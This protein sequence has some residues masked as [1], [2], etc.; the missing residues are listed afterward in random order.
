MTQ[1]LRPARSMLQRSTSGV[2]VTA[3]IKHT[4]ATQEIDNM[5][6]GISVLQNDLRGDLLVQALARMREKL[7]SKFAVMAA[8]HQM[9]VDCS[10]YLDAAELAT[11]LNQLG[12]KLGKA[13][14]TL[15]FCSID[16]DGSGEIDC[17]EFL[18]M[19]FNPD[20]E[21][22]AQGAAN[23]SDGLAKWSA[24][25]PP[26]RSPNDP[27]KYI[28]TS[29]KMQTRQHDVMRRAAA[30]DSWPS[31]MLHEPGHRTS[32]EIEVA[33]LAAQPRD[34]PQINPANHPRTFM[35]QGGEEDI[36]S[37]LNT[38]N[39]RY[40]H[41]KD[42]RK[43]KPSQK[44]SAKI[45][46]TTREQLRKFEAVAGL[47]EPPS[48]DSNAAA[49]DVH[50]WMHKDE[51]KQANVM[52]LRRFQERAAGADA[53]VR[54]AQ[55]YFEVLSKQGATRMDSKYYDERSASEEALAIAEAVAM[56]AHDALADAQ[57]RYGERSPEVREVEQ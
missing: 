42:G 28:E 29:A 20:P 52:K 31:S 45:A 49:K 25:V 6:G 47:R 41:A 35:K 39:N 1:T 34:L 16:V 3:Y 44:N 4:A 10:G 55:K 9:D 57:Q 8:F 11:A 5:R 17:E 2:D 15:V 24:W 32:A 43:V 30:T 51:M 12:V 26:A 18:D 14:A 48:G 46:N 38:W 13:Q 36:Q 7:V 27:V 22:E 40:R 37:I 19:V 33:T 54:K 50:F 53:A 23:A 56:E 21:G